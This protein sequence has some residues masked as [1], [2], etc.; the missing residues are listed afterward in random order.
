MPAHVPRFQESGQ[1]SGIDTPAQHQL[2]LI[3]PRLRDLDLL[4][5]PMML[6]TAG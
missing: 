5:D 1:P 3:R 2:Q 4:H 6:T